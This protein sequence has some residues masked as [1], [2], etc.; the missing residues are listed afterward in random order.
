MIA[1]ITGDLVNSTQLNK[2]DYRTTVD[3]LKKYLTQIATEYSGIFAV[4]RGDGFQLVTTQYSQ[5][6]TIMLKIKLWL[7]AG[8]QAPVIQCALAGAC[9]MGSIEG[10]DPGENTGPV[11]IRSGRTLDT[12]RGAQL[13]IEIQDSQYNTALKVLCSQQSYILN[14]LTAGQCELLYLYLEQQC[15]THQQ[16]ASALGTSRQNISERLRAAGAETVTE[17]IH[18][19][20]TSCCE[21]HKG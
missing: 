12:L 9:G 1:V 8:T 5:I 7:A 15:P 17:F 13:S 21:V 3:A 11:Y 10:E 18:F 16:L 6:A 2:H 4:Y 20:K 19:T 14:R